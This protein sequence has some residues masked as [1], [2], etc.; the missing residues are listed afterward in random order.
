M[1]YTIN[2]FCDLHRACRPGRIWAN[3]NCVSMQDA[4]D[5][6]PPDYLIWVALRPGVLSA[7]ELLDFGNW[8]AKRIEQEVGTGRMSSFE[9]AAEVFSDGYAYLGS[10]AVSPGLLRCLAI[11]NAWAK[12]Y[13]WTK[14]D[15]STS[16]PEDVRPLQAQ[17]LRENTKPNFRKPE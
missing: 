9:N 13:T 1:D 12:L 14:E 15:R 8:V 11:T 7:Q 4:W 5:K 3:M 10:A 17:W 16:S 6:L 2:E